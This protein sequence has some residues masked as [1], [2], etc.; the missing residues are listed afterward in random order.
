MIIAFGIWTIAAFVFAGIGISAG[1]SKKPV[2]F[3][4]T[5]EPPKVTDVKKYNHAVS[6]LWIVVALIFEAMGF[7]FLF[8]KQN[9]PFVFLIVFGV[10]AL[11]IGMMIAYLRIEEKYAEKKLITN[12]DG[13]GEDGLIRLGQVLFPK[14][15]GINQIWNMNFPGCPLTEC[16][17]LLRAR[18]D[19][20]VI[21][22]SPEWKS[23]VMHVP[24]VDAQ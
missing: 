18:K 3:F 2:G 7:P 15:L 9:S 23:S 20:N 1:K 10:V 11:V 24:S 12:D 14:P 13:I 16:K 4:T 22:P 6:L 8:L 17:G 21:I 19:G 5:V